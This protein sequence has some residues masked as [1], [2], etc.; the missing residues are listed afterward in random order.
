[1]NDSDNLSRFLFEHTAIRGNLVHLDASWRAILANHD[2][3]DAVRAVLGDAMA[4]VALLAATIKFDGSLVLQAQGQGPLRTVVAQMTH[5][6][7]IRG[8]AHWDGEVP[9]EGGL[10][11]RFGGGHL[12]LTVERRDGEPYQGVVP[13]EGHSLAAAIERYF[14][15]SEQLPTRLWLAADGQ[16]AAGLLLQRLPGDGDPEEDWSRIGMLAATITP[17]ELLQ[18]SRHKLLHRLFHEETVR[19]FDAEPIAFRCS[20]SRTRI[21]DTVRLLGEGELETLLD[22]QDV[23]QVTCEFCNREYRLDPVDVR[24]LFAADTRHEPPLL[25]H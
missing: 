16:R 13:L 15:D 24:Q 17:G 19:L 25:H 18:L 11:E 5:E 8:L 21:A 14:R 20:C 23:I 2:Y 1:M 12:V 4:A 9:A 6:R 3:P 22:E 10:A 7:T